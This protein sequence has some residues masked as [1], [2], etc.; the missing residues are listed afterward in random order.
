[1]VPST[2]RDARGREA[3]SAADR[4]G[5]G[6]FSTAPVAVDL[7]PPPRLQAGC[8]WWCPNNGPSKHGNVADILAAAAV[9]GTLKSSLRIAELLLPLL[10]LSRRPSPLSFVALSWDLSSTPTLSS[11]SCGQLLLERSGRCTVVSDWADRAMASITSTKCNA[12]APVNRR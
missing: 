12:C 6:P 7:L 2:S 4:P 3:R 1:M 10:S 5:K 11:S 8:R 9:A